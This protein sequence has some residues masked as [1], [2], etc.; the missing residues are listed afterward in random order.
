MTRRIVVNEGILALYRGITPP[1]LS[2]S[3][4]NTIN[5]TSYSYFRQEIFDADDG[6]DNRN[7]LSGLS[8]GPIAGS[9]STVE[10]VIKVSVFC[11]VSSA[12]LLEQASHFYAL[13]P[14]DS[15]AG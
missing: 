11:M 2:L 3:A 5:F 8:I 10:N 14:V 15:N 1:L 12:T 9:V 7:C 6:W 4:L 13:I